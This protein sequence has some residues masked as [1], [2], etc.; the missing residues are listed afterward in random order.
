MAAKM[1]KQ[2][3]GLIVNGAMDY[4]RGARI[5][6]PSV[7]VGEI[8]VFSAGRSFRQR[9]LQVPVHEVVLAERPSPRQ[10]DLWQL[11]AEG[12]DYVY[13]LKAVD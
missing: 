11:R 13:A 10:L 7:Q 8:R 1:C 3:F 5:N 12:L 4:F 6:L 2:T 9:V